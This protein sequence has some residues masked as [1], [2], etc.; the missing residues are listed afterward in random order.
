[1]IVFS[2]EL[3]ELLGKNPQDRA[4]TFDVDNP[5]PERGTIVPLYTRF[6]RSLQGDPIG[7]GTS[8]STGSANPQQPLGN[9]ADARSCVIYVGA[10]DI[11]YRVDGGVPTPAGDQTIQAGSTITITGKPTMLGFTFAG[12]SGPVTIY[13]T[14]YD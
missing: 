11:L 3:D 10:G 13:Y 2:N 4:S 1:M 5:R 6:M 7:Y 9:V 8:T 12:K 14:F